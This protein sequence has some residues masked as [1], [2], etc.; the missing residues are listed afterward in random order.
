MLLSLLGRQ[1]R[2]LRYAKALAAEGR[3]PGEI[4]GKTGIPP[5]A[6]RK[7]LDM[8]RA[9]TLEQLGQMVLRCT[10]NQSLDLKRKSL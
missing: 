10:A 5:F 4:A 3:Q 1:C 6:V 2:Q 7:T 8:V 9:Y